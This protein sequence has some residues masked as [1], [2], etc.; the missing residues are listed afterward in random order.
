MAE[1]N[2]YAPPADDG[3]ALSPRGKPETKRGVWREG[4]SLVMNKDGVRLPKR[5]VVC[6]A[7]MAGDRARRKFSWHP[8]WVYATLFIGALIYVIVAAITRKH[9]TVAIGLCEE[10]RLRRRNGIILGWSAVP[11]GLI[12]I[13][14]GVN[15]ATALIYLGFLVLIALPITGAYLARVAYPTRIDEQHLWLH[16]GP[17]F[18]ASIAERDG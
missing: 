10:H 15:A 18:L 9:A 3:P 14:A 2:P 4:G 11:V 13:V 8:R 5:C 16:V 7:P 17:P 1:L 6:N 12:L